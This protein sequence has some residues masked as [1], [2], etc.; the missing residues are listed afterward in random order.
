MIS[1]L[2]WLRLSTRYDDNDYVDDRSDYDDDYND[3]KENY[4]YF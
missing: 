1:Q 3:I 2:S 4:I